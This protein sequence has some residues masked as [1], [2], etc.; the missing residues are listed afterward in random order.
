M[1]W[2]RIIASRLKK[3]KGNRYRL[4]NPPHEVSQCWQPWQ[5]HWWILVP[6]Q[7]T[8]CKK[9]SVKHAAGM[10]FWRC[11]RNFSLDYPPPYLWLSAVMHLGLWPS[12]IIATRYDLGH[13]VAGEIQVPLNAVCHPTSRCQPN[14]PKTLKTHHNSRI[15]THWFDVL[16]LFHGH[17]L[18]LVDLMLIDEESSM[19]LW[20][21]CSCP[22]SMLL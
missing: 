5:W 2:A 1:G 22:W 11:S 9:Q 6:W 14:R 3:G 13:P 12:P 15:T 4:P 18:I 17:A 16:C 7:V 8:N 21:W 10:V 19:E 20:F